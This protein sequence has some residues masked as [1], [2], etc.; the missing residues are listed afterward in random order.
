MKTVQP[1]KQRRMI[2]QAPSHIRYKLFSASLSPSLKVA[3]LVD[4]IP[5]RVGDTVRI[6]RGDRKGSEGKV[7]KVDRK[8]LRIIVEGVTREKVDGTSVPTPVHPSKVM[9]MNLNLD[10][11]W[12]RKSLKV[13]AAKEA[14][15]PKEKPVKPKKER[16]KRKPRKAP[17]EKTVASKRKRVKKS[18][19]EKKEEG[20][21]KSG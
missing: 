20:E 16:K 2:Y 1:R 9:I 4:S 3:H 8:K 13:E 19:E 7:T 18:A 15:K 6:M 17:A 21:A 5:V 14:E 11:K 10:D 12:R